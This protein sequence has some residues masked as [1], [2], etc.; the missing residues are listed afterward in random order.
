MQ[1]Q[2]KKNRQKSKLFQKNYPIF[3]KKNSE[4]TI[5]WTLHYLLNF[6]IIFKIVN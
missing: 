2:V 1:L 4:K 5:Y 6:L 3:Q